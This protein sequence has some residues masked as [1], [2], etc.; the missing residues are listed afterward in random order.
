[1]NKRNQ[2]G[3]ERP[4]GAPVPLRLRFEEAVREQDKNRR[5]DDYE[6]P[7]AI[8][9]DFVVHGRF[10]GGI[11][12]MLTGLILAAARRTA[13]VIPAAAMPPMPAVHKNVH[14]RAGQKERPRE[15][16]DD[17]GPMLRDQEIGPYREKPEQDEVRARSEEAGL[18]IILVVFHFSLHSS[19]RWK[20]GRRI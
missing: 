7:Q 6:R 10:P 19:D 18:A 9:G 17:M 13:V 1:V 5:V 12:S 3:T 14:Q 16:W 15:E 8:G 20:A 2:K 11:V 4:E